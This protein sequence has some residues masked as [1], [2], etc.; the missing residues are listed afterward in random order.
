MR[1]PSEKF[2]HSIYEGYTIIISPSMVGPVML[3][4]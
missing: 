3:L 1:K 2:L 4:P